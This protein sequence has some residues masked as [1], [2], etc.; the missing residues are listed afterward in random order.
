[1]QPNAPSGTHTRKARGKAPFPGEE[2]LAVSG[3]HLR[4]GFRG[5]DERL[6]RN[7]RA[8]SNRRSTFTATRT[9]AEPSDDERMAVLLSPCL[10]VQWF[11]MTLASKHDDIK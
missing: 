4:R 1:M 6:I 5:I 8:S 2:G 9:E 11:A 3:G 7:A 10:S